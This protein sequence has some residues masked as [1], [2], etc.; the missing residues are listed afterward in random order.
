MGTPAE[1]PRARLEL[2]GTYRPPLGRLG[3]ALD[4]TVLHQVAAVTI[5]TLL[6]SVATSL[7]S[8]A[9]AIDGATLRPQPDT[10]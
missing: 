5:R 10:T 7:I 9:T 2:T 6:H 1:S 8:P 3:A 4:H